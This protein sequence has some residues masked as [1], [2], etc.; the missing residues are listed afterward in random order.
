VVNKIEKPGERDVAGILRQGDH[1]ARVVEYDQQCGNSARS[2][3]A[4][5][6][7]FH[8]SIARLKQSKA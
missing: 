2:L 1:A 3:N 5:Q 4:Q 8:G 7:F 6:P